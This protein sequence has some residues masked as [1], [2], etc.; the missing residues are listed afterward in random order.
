VV[1]LDLKKG[2]LRVGGIKLGTLAD[3]FFL[4]C[5]DTAPVA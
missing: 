4:R 5:F 2:D 3:A 1:E